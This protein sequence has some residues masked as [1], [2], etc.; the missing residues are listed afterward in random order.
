MLYLELI[1]NL[2]RNKVVY[3]KALIH[4]EILH[5]FLYTSRIYTHNNSVPFN[6]VKSATLLKKSLQIHSS[7]N[8]CLPISTDV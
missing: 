8:S 5:N 7:Q 4:F 3:V 6:T 2:D 1:K